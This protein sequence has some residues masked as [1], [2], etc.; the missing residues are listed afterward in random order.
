MVG[1]IKNNGQD[2]KT[3]P[4]KP[5]VLTSPA[6]AD[7]EAALKALVGWV[8]DALARPLPVGEKTSLAFVEKLPEE[9]CPLDAEP[10]DWTTFDSTSEHVDAVRK[11][12]KEASGKWSSFD[13]AG[14]GDKP[15]FRAVFGDDLPHQADPLVARPAPDFAATAVRLWAPILDRQESGK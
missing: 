14:E 4:F 12:L 3:R 11:A 9:L 8:K 2:R 7:P 6:P 1:V 15:H 13:G 10:Y 5:L